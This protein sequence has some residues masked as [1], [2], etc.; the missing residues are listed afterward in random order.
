MA[1]VRRLRCGAGNTLTDTVGFVRHLPQQD[2]EHRRSGCT[3]RCADRRHE[4]TVRDIIDRLLSI[5]EQAGTARLPLDYGGGY[6]TN[7]FDYAQE[8]RFRAPADS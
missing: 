5:A 8:D 2:R 1:W 6:F 7:A 4:T 3:Q